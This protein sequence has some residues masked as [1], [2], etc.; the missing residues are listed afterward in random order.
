VSTQDDRQL[1]PEA[2]ARILE[3]SLKLARPFDLVT[4]LS[5]VVAAARYI[6]RADR[7]SVFLYEEA[8]GEL[9]M[10]VVEDIAPIRVP[11]GHGIVGHCARE[12]RLINVPDCYA[13]ERFNPEVD[14][15]SGFRT[16]CLL[17]IP[18][19]AQDDRL[20]GVLQL[21]NKRGGVFDEK[22]EL[23]ASALGAQCAVALQRAQ[24]IEALL[25]A[26]HLHEEIRVAREI[27]MSGL[28]DEMPPLAGYDGAGLFLPTDQTGGDLFDFVPVGDAGMFLLLGDA[29]GHGIGPALSA[30]QVRAMVRVALRLGADLDAIHTHVNNQLLDDLPDDRFVCA[31][32]GLLDAGTHTVRYH[33]AGQGPLLHL[34]AQS[35]EVSWYGATTIP[36]GALALAAP[37]PAQAVRLEPGDVLGLIS[38][39]VYE[40]E[41]GA[42]RHFGEQR[43]AELIGRLQHLPMR[44]VAD[45]LLAALRKFGGGAAQA[46]DIT[47]VLLRRLPG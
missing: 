10:T 19:I 45:E 1:P 11:L 2:L 36:M 4:M 5:E 14:R 9:V 7:G 26:E 34:H 3:V 47:I 16:R 18:L 24:A 37:D 33:A 42:R 27:Q 6:L 23:A 40:Y 46:D 29:T 39:G 31:F 38:D 12:R 30:T 28:P 20:V 17:S 43:V 15:A 21:L 25:A 32:L 35:G 22:D 44:Q 13:D 41:D 8:S